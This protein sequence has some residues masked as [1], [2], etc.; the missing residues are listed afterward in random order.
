MFLH[1]K[2]RPETSWKNVNL[3]FGM[4]TFGRGRVY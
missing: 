1:S 4:T 2:L 3:S